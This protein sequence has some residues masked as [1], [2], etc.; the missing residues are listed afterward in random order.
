MAVNS[1]A[2]STAV[3]RGD[4]ASGHLRAPL[5]VDPEMRGGGLEECVVVDEV[6]EVAVGKDE[7]ADSKPCG[8]IGYWHGLLCYSR[9]TQSYTISISDNHLQRCSGLYLG[10]ALR[11]GTYDVSKVYDDHTMIGTQIEL[12]HNGSIV[13][14]DVS[15]VHIM[16][17][18]N[19]SDVTVD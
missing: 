17:P 5:V 6:V 11:K 16:D 14:R 8:I 13:W 2:D 4:G 1:T 18:N 3:G 15:I 19:D 12:F 9:M 10:Y 7:D